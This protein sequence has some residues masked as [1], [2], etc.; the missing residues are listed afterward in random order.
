MF[1][2]EGFLLEGERKGFL[3]WFCVWGDRD[4]GIFYKLYRSF[5]SRLVMRVFVFCLKFVVGFR[6]VRKMV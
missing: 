3:G 1:G 5:I 4:D 2:F 6:E